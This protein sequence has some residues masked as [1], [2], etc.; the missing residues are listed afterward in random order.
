MAA[1][2]VDRVLG[3]PA[4]WGLGVALDVDGYGMGGVGGSF[5]WWSTEGDYA[6]GFLT[7]VI[8]DHDRATRVDNA[9]RACLGLPAPVDRPIGLWRLARA[10]RDRSAERAER[11]HG[12]GRPCP[13]PGEGGR[14]ASCAPIAT[15][16]MSTRPLTT[17]R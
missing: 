14:L 1:S 4:E 13:S 16:R 2:G 17:P 8:A 6:I 5:G 11:R 10:R 12:R 7:G 9:V 15:T 3:E